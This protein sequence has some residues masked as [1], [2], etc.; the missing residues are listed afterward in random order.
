MGADVV[1]GA[2][3][4]VERPGQY[5]TFAE[6]PCNVCSHDVTGVYDKTDGW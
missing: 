4:S 1:S 6:C 3:T 2:V 5:D